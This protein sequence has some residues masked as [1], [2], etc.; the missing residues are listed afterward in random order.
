MGLRYVEE[1]S[2]RVEG[3]GGGWQWGVERGKE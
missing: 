3:G 1:M 2:P